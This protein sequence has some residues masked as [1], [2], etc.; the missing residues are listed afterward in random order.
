MIKGKTRI[1]MVGG[2]RYFLIPESL[3]NDSAFPFFKDSK[4]EMEIKE[5]EV[6][7]K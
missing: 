7:I 1:I 5:K 4:L 2:S 3:V 6:I